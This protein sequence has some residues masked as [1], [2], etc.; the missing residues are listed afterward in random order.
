[1]IYIVKQINENILIFEK[2]GIRNKDFLKWVGIISTVRRSNKID[3]TDEIVPQSLE[4][5][6]LT[7]DGPLISV[8]S[9][10]VYETL[11]KLIWENEKC[12]THH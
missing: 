3:P 8:T 10:I 2:R 7:L 5:A 6:A 1:M 11:I 12:P 4:A 9:E